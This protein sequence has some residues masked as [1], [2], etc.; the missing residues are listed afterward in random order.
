MKRIDE[1]NIHPSI[2]CY[3]HQRMMSPRVQEVMEI[4]SALSVA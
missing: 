2:D 1:V 3:D 4:G